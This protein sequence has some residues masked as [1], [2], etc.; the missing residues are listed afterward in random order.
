MPFN[1]RHSFDE[2]IEY[3]D[4]ITK[5]RITEQV[6]VILVANKV[7]KIV[8]Y[9]SDLKGVFAKKLKGV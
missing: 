7:I 8:M 9:I 6:P 4:L 5:V 2:A 1:F 3:R